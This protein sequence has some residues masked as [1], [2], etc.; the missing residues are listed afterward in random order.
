MNGD[1]C[2]ICMGVDLEIRGHWCHVCGRNREGW[3][4][5]L[6]PERRRK[7]MLGYYFGATAAWVVNL[8]VVAGV[9]IAVY[10]LFKR[11]YP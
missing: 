11:F 3:L 5:T 1:G 6:P 2:D 10:L 7:A 8:T 9:A 4:R